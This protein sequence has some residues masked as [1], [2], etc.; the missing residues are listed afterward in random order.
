MRIMVISGVEGFI[1]ILSKLEDLGISNIY[2]Y[3]SK[4]NSDSAAPLIVL[5]SFVD[6]VV[7]G[8]DAYHFPNLK[9][10]IEEA[11]DRYTPVMSEEAL[12][13]GGVFDAKSN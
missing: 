10:V 6:A 13:S 11:R 7:L 2:F 9:R 5:V 1:E 4:T 8:K 3:N 12:K